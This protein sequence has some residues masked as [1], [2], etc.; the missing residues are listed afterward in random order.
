MLNALKS[1][2]NGCHQ[3]SAGEAFGKLNGALDWG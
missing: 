1:K 2:E 3:I